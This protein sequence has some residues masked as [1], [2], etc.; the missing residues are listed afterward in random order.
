[1]PVPVLGEFT[2]VIF[3]I[4]SRLRIRPGCCRPGDHRGLACVCQSPG[5]GGA[6]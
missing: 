3:L 4:V 6:S 2:G 1:M 5:W